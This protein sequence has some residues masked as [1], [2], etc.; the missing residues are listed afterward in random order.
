MT[1][2]KHVETE[3]QPKLMEDFTAEEM[4]Q[5]EEAYIGKPTVTAGPGMQLPVQQQTDILYAYSVMMTVG[6]EVRILKS[7][8]IAAVRE[9]A[10]SD[11]IMTSRYIHDTLRSNNN[12]S[13][14]PS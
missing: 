13:T 4:K 6:G 11:I 14:P 9:P 12:G 7:E 2:G 10:T 3:G 1:R 8:H 5:A